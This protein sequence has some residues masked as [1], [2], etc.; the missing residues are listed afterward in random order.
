MSTIL[1]KIAASLATRTGWHFRQLYL[2]QTWTFA[3]IENEAGQV[4]SGL[5]AT[6]ASE[7]VEAHPVFS[8]GSY[9]VGGLDPLEVAALAVQPDPVGTAVGL[10]TINALLEPDAAR[11]EDVDAADW[12]V[13]HGRGR[14]MVMV[15]RFPFIDEL[16][17]VVGQLQVL[18]LGPQPGEYPA[19]EAPRLIPQAEI[20]AITSST[21]VNHSL[22]DLLALAQPATRVMLLGPSTPLSPVLFEFGVDLLSGVQVIDLAVVLDAVSRGLSFRKLTGVRR[23]TLRKETF[24]K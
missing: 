12:L 24:L 23:V 1:E 13:E 20:I 11:L 22:D 6:P 5:A 18:E 4:R 2:G 15:G 21:L 7:L 16:E 10:A 9:P 17:P 8:P 19:S 3:V 14:R